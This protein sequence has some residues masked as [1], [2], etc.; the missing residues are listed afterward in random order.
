MCVLLLFN[1]IDYC[2][3]VNYFRNGG[4][5]IQYHVIMLITI[6]IAVHNEYM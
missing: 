5:D 1:R 3:V 4:M 6:N 2:G